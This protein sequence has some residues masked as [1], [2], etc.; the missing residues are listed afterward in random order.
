MEKA[1]GSTFTAPK[2]TPEQSERLVPTEWGVETPEW[3]ANNIQT[4]L[5]VQDK[6]DQA[7]MAGI[8]PGFLRKVRMMNCRKAVFAVRGTTPLREMV[9]VRER[10][11]GKKYV[12]AGVEELREDLDRLHDAHI[13][14]TFGSTEDLHIESSL[15]ELTA[16]PAVVHVF[17][18]PE[19]FVPW[20]TK[21][22]LTGGLNGAE[23]LNSLHREHTF[24]VLGKRDDGNY[25]CF[26]KQGPEQWHK[27]EVVT[28]H[29]IEVRSITPKEGETYLSF[30]GPIEEAQKSGDAMP[31]QNAAA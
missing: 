11:D 13:S 19:K 26:H 24:L 6:V 30:V 15:D 27:M 14:P 23:Y 12:S 10:E 5:R 16:F 18:I 28:L 21:K 1:P 22:A 4:A 17:R 31:S 9:R 8:R 29:E 3:L 7:M 20:F 25:I 2:A